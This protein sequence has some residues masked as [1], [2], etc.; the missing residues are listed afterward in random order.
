MDGK[1]IQLDDVNT[2]VQ[3]RQCVEAL[4]GHLIPMTANVSVFLEAW[5]GG[6]Q[7][8]TLWADLQTMHAHPKGPW[9]G[10]SA[11]IG[12]TITKRQHYRGR[13]ITIQMPYFA[14][15]F[16]Q[17]IDVIAQALK[18]PMRDGDEPSIPNP[19]RDS[20][21]YNYPPEERKAIADA[22]REARRNPDGQPSSM[23]AWAR[24]HYCISGR[25][26]GRY[27]E[28]FPGA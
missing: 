10:A 26:L 16:Q 4:F 5:P 2:D 18:H 13:R 27:L 14:R 20:G 22:Y 23:N 21:H 19:G 25:T 12:F 1:E 7:D 9:R 6:W 28:E 24:S 11:E 15:G 17:E 3:A 8:D